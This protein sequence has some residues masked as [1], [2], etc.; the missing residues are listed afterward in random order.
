MNYQQIVNLTA[1]VILANNPQQAVMVWGPPG[2]GKSHLAT[3]GL[4][5]AMGMAPIGHPE[6]PV[7]MFRPSNHDPVDLT[8]LPL[9]TEHSTTWITPDFLK[10]LNGLAERH[11]RA[12][13]VVDEINQSAPAM[14]N[15]LNGLL[16]D[17]MIAQFRLDPR[18]SIVCTGNRQQDRATSNRMPGHTSNRLWHADMESDIEGF[19]KVAL[20][21][22]HFPVYLVSFLQFVPSLLNAYDPDQ[23]QNPTERTWDLFAKSSGG[24]KL[25]IEATAVVAKGFVGEGAATQVAA[26]RQIWHELPNIDATLLDP[27]NA[28]LPTNKSAQYAM[29]GALAERANKF[30][31]EAIV[32]YAK[33]MPKPFEV[34]AVKNAYARAPD[35]TATRTFIEWSSENS[36]VFTA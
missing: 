5:Q 11:G 24:D 14:F 3:V 7:R 22:P 16:L 20:T 25:P 30:T 17:G 6:S 33:R 10:E 9:V 4:P 8:G 18:V 13:F 12:L 35:I 34:L 1:N 27:Q 2:C 21:W 28:P 15:T 26:F 19:V 23:R 32:E 31:F 29:C 36:N